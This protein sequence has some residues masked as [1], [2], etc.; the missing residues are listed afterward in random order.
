MYLSGQGVYNGFSKPIRVE[1]RVDVHAVREFE[2]V[3]AIETRR[4]VDLRIDHIEGGDVAS[5]QTIV[6]D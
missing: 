1:D 4:P 6:A 2:A 3:L 5:R